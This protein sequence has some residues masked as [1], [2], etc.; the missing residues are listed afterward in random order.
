MVALAGCGSQ[1]TSTSSSSGT[2]LNDA[3]NSDP[4]L[5]EAGSSDPSTGDNTSSVGSPFSIMMPPYHRCNSWYRAFTDISPITITIITQ[6]ASSSAVIEVTR[7]ADGILYGRMASSTE[8]ATSEAFTQDF[9]RYITLVASNDAWRIKKVT[10]G[11]ARST[12]NTSS[13][14]MTS[15]VTID[16]VSIYDVTSGIT[17]EITSAP[18]AEGPWI[19]YETIATTE[20]GHNLVVTAVV[21]PNAHG[22]PLVFIWPRMDEALALSPLFHRRQFPS[23]TG[24][25]YT[26]SITVPSASVVHKEKKRMIIG[27][28]DT[29]T[30]ASGEALGAYDFTSWH[31]PVKVVK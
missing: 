12:A 4:G 19:D 26:T 29:G 18:S 9:T 11:I 20:P 17:F 8:A 2:S 16:S 30:L 3:I 27:A 15:D 5:F 24:S 31:I 23:P 22:Q 14:S 28:F 7:E 21:E 6:E 25:T 1:S 13:T 10:Q